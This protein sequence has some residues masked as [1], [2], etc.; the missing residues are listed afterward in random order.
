M[1]YGLP[2]DGGVLLKHVGL[3]KE[4]YSFVYYLCICWFC[5]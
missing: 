5:I 4:M 3:N 1:V 2:E